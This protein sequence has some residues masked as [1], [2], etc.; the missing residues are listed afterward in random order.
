[1]GDAFVLLDDGSHLDTCGS[2]DK[3]SIWLTL[4]N[5]TSYLLAAFEDNRVDL[6]TGLLMTTGYVCKGVFE[7]QR[8]GYDCYQDANYAAAKTLLPSEGA[9]VED[10]AETFTM[11][12]VSR[13]FPGQDGPC[14]YG[15]TDVQ[16]AGVRG[17][18][19]QMFL[20]ARQGK[21]KSCGLTRFDNRAFQGT[22]WIVTA[23]VVIL[24]A[25]IGFLGAAIVGILGIFVCYIVM[26]VVIYTAA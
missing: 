4:A 21:V 14:F 23:L 5:G 7:K 10:L 16:V 11:T 17:P 8:G 25:Y 2:K 18:Y 9:T 19:N 13:P 26:P 12:Q 6:D 20:T 24:A 3:A 22:M 15:D 1:V